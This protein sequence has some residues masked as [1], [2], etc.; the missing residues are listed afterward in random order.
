MYN[1][2]KLIIE[3]KNNKHKIL[4]KFVSST[5]KKVCEFNNYK[6]FANLQIKIT[7]VTSLLKLVFELFFCFS[8]INIAKSVGLKL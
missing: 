2:V 8:L 1:I 6:N 3:N 7:K 5:K 4:L